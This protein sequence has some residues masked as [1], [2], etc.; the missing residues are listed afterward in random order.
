MGVLY[1]LSGL[2]VSEIHN[3]VRLRH[4]L[5]AFR[6][7]CLSIP[8]GTDLVVPTLLLNLAISIVSVTVASKVLYRAG[9]IVGLELAS[10]EV[11]SRWAV[12]SSS[13]SMTDASGDTEAAS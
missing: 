5:I 9:L 13:P 4:M 8:L 10:A 7:S 3:S 2:F 1:R 11:R 12:E 6:R